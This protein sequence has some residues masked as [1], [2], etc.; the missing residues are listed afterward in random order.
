MGNRSSPLSLTSREMTT[1][2]LSYHAGDCQH[3]VS[4]Q[5]YH[6]I[7]SILRLLETALTVFILMRSSPELIWDL[8]W[9]LN[10]VSFWLSPS[11]PQRMCNS[12]CS[13][14]KCFAFRLALGQSFSF[15]ENTNTTHQPLPALSP[16]SQGH[17]LGPGHVLVPHLWWSPALGQTQLKVI[18]HCHEE[19]LERDRRPVQEPLQEMLLK[20][21]ARRRQ[22]SET[23][24]QQG[25]IK[26]DPSLQSSGIRGIVS[27]ST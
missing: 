6:K 17:F 22:K 2:F 13:K 15:Y 3:R 14:L 7:K 27:N 18:F 25:A 8:H 24:L 26:A 12:S 4:L 9:L 23:L 21:S 20:W 1:Q 11:F 10:S 16:I 19:V 5:L